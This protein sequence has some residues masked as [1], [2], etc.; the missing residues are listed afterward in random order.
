MC[1]Q[2]VLPA[3]RVR[4]IAI[5]SDS[6]KGEVFPASLAGSNLP[7]LPVDRGNGLFI[8]NPFGLIRC[9]E[10]QYRQR[11]K[12]RLAA[13]AIGTVFVC[14]ITSYAGWLAGATENAPP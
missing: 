7:R 8:G 2:F 1:S 14:A 5:L 12:L 3:R 11:P 13:E 10:K 9:I 4:K 6:L